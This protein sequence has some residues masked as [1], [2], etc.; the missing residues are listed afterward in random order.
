M[1]LP[2]KYA[3]KS[4]DDMFF[5]LDIFKELQI[6]SKRDNIPNTIFYGQH[7]SGRRTLVSAFLEMIYDKSVHNL[8]TTEFPVVSTGTSSKT[9]VQL[10]QSNYHIII[11]P[12]GTNFDKHIIAC[13]V[14]AYVR[15]VPLSVFKSTKTFKIV[16]INNADKLTIHAQTTLRRTMEIYSNTC[17]FILWCTKYSS[18]IDPIRSR[19]LPIRVPVPTDGEIIGILVNICNKD[20]IKLTLDDTSKIVRST[21]GRIKEAL[22][23]LQILKIRQEEELEKKKK[24]KELKKKLL[25]S[26][27]S[28]NKSDSEE[29]EMITP[30]T[31]YEITINKIVELLKKPNIKLLDSLKKSMY[32][33]IITNLPPAHIITS[34]TDKLLQS[35]ELTEEQM[36]NIITITADYEHRTLLSRR[37]II[38][39]EAYIIHIFDILHNKKD[40]KNPIKVS[41]IAI[42]YKKKEEV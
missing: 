4:I 41:K 6:I 17:K 27:D 1:F 40:L 8:S 19:C 36:C 28:D 5:H 18:I 24:L 15:S 42:E 37:P 20:K 13:V 2:D 7:E 38:Q 10:K 9:I 33:I 30:E 35:I 21:N 26:D 31:I 39:I 23:K 29:M 11:E 34:I 3:P 14:K 16:L 12:T 22:W 32:E 25:D